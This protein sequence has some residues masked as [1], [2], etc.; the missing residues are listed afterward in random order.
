MV[1]SL[2]AGAY[3]QNFISLNGCDSTHQVDLMVLPNIATSESINLCE[4]NSI[5]LFGVIVRPYHYLNRAAE[6]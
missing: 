4:G 5:Q 1:I 2:N 3:S 6:I